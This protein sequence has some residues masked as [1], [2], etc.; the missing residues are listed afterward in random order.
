MLFLLLKFF[1]EIATAVLMQR[2]F[3]FFQAP[4]ESAKTQ[5]YTLGV[6]RGLCPFFHKHMLLHIC[7]F[8]FF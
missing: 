3:Y 2:I 5:M 1:F 6:L 8:Y 4:K 7:F